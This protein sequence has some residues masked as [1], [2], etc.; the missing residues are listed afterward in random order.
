M[1]KGVGHVAIVVKDIKES[2][3][4]YCDIMG[5]KMVRK[6]TQP[7]KG[8][9]N[10]YDLTMDNTQ[11]GEVQLI[12]Y[13]KPAP[14]GKYISNSEITGVQ[15]VGILIEDM[16]ATYAYL[17]SKGVNTFVE[18]PKPPKP[19]SPRVARLLDP[20]GVVLE[21]ITFVNR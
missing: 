21:L 3:H 4:F 19:G 11:L 5:F 14:C 6:F 1:I 18:E 12:E 13:V 2:L 16:D 10:V 20:N 7:W 9:G 15:H 17:K 8:G